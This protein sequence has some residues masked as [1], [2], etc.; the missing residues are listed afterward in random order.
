MGA[1]VGFHGSLLAMSL[2]VACADDDAH[3]PPPASPAVVQ[4]TTYNNVTNIYNAPNPANDAAPA[5][6]A[7]VP[8]AA[9]TPVALG[10]PTFTA[11]A[12]AA[13]PSVTSPHAS[14]SNGAARDL[15]STGIA[16]C[17]EYLDRIESCS[18][19]L[20][21]H[22]AEADR[23]FQRIRMSLDMTRR[24]WRNA[25]TNTSAASELA[26]TCSDARALYESSVA[27]KCP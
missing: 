25:A 19:T 27:D 13:P 4:N 22:N 18:R 1:S 15:R 21:P 10:A 24:A 11:V 20:L 9:V 2:L 3:L 7:D 14:T 12:D 16:A 6:A 5:I 17:D 8:D 23:G 26:R